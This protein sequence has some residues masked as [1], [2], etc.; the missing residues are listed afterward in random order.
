MSPIRAFNPGRRRALERGYSMIE[1]SVA[2]LIALFLLSGMF[3][4][5]QNTKKTS[6]N[7]SGLAQ[8]QEEERVAMTMMTDVIQEAGYYAR[9]DQTTTAATFLSDSLFSTN[10][11]YIAGTG[12]AGNSV[13]SVRYQGDTTGTVLDCLG[14]TIANGINEDMTFFVQAG[15]NNNGA[16][17]LFCAVNGNTANAVPLV[18]Y[19]QSLSILYGVDSTA[20]GSAN[21]YVQASSVTNWANVYSV[22][23]QVTF[24]NPLYPQPGQIQYLT[25][26]RVIGIM[27]MNGAN[28]R[29]FY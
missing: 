27:A 6:L 8:L 11:Q 3:M 13:I 20:S 14:S 26:S 1:L 10:G 29:K 7:Q 12:A 24:L 9:P 19:V 17:E 18:P 16:M 2:V 4:I 28:A 25:F 5:L 21:T 23:L 15:Q 22:N